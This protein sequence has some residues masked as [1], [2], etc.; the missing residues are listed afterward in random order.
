MSESDHQMPP[1][2]GDAYEIFEDAI[3]TCQNWAKEHGYALSEV[4]TQ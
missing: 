3:N 2:P 1:L 4:K